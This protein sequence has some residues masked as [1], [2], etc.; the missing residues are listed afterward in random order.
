MKRLI[1]FLPLPPVAEHIGYFLKRYSLT[2]HAS[3]CG[4]AKNLGSANNGLQPS[5]GRRSD[6]DITYRFGGHPLFYGSIGPKKDMSLAGLRAPS[7]NVG[8]ERA[9]E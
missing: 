2:Q 6:D 3:G 8:H 1:D 9:S 4:M 7:A 5:A